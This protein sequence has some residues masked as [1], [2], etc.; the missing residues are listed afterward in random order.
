MFFNVFNVIVSYGNVCIHGVCTL[1]ICISRQHNFKPPL[2]PYAFTVQHRS[3][4]A[5]TGRSRNLQAI[6]VDYRV[7]CLGRILVQD[8]ILERILNTISGKT[9][10]RFLTRLSFWIKTIITSHT[11]HE[12]Y[13]HKSWCSLY[14]CAHELLKKQNGSEVHL[15]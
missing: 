11:H 1:Y 8:K 14:L 7:H 3:T 5:G 9:T 4:I 15:C 13:R 6:Q 12:I 2:I 10:W